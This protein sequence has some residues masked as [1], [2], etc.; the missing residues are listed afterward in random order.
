MDT[1]FSEYLYHPGDDK[2]TL[3]LK[4]IWYIF[5]VTGLPVLMLAAYMIGNSYG[6][7]VVYLNITF[8]LC[9]SVPLIVF[10]FYK[11][12]IENYGF[13]SQLS[14]VILTSIKVYFMGGMML[15]GTPV[16]VGFLAPLFALIFPQKKRAFLVLFLYV[17]GMVLA[18]LL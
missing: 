8:I 10:H 5:S 13:F 15:T 12:N 18:T 17:T 11:N 4:K 2:E 14:I 9:L 6:N 3:I 1:K 7:I 16:Y